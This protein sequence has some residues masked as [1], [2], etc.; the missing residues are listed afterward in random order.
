MKHPLTYHFCLPVDEERDG[1]VDYFKI[2]KRPMDLGTVQNNL[3]KEAYST[4]EQW[5][6]DIEEIWENC[7]TYN[8][9]QGLI[10]LF[11]KDFRR[12]FKKE[13]K[14]L[15]PH[16]MKKIGQ[17][18]STAI[19]QFNTYL[20]QPPPKL[21]NSVFPPSERYRDADLRPFSD[22]DLIAMISAVDD[23]SPA[24]QAAFG[25]IATVFDFPRTRKG[26]AEIIDVDAKISIRA[27]LRERQGKVVRM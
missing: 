19:H 6:H 26:D 21:A 10:S 17:D 11:A 18:L 14:A 1:A 20:D 23:L 24:D 2:I 4:I 7:K 9:K 13:S 5:Q 25:Q 27:F 12:L 3:T 16:S 8:S 15:I 22:R